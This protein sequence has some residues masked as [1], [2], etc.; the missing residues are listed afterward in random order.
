M[1]AALEAALRFSELTSPIAVSTENADGT[2]SGMA[3]VSHPIPTPASDI[4]NASQCL[5]KGAASSAGIGVGTLADGHLR[6]AALPLARA[7]RAARRS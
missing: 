2:T 4:H 1:F 6:G 5:W 7:A 3:T